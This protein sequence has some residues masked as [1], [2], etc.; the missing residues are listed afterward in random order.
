MHPSLSLERTLCACAPDRLHATSS[1]PSQWHPTPPQSERYRHSP[2]DDNASFLLAPGRFCQQQNISGKLHRGGSD[3]PFAVTNDVG[4]MIAFID[5][6]FEYL[7]LLPG[8]QRT[9]KSSNQLFGFPREHA[10][11]DNFYPTRFSFGFVFVYMWFN[12][13]PGNLT[14][15]VR[16]FPRCQNCFIA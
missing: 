3:C 14:R 7:N 15:V 4:F 13:H 1:H 5:S 2:P 16:L 12:E 9:I 8:Y 6:R 11:T 10:T